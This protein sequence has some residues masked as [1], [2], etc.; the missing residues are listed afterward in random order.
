MTKG[1]AIEPSGA[2]LE[3]AAALDQKYLVIPNPLSLSRSLRSFS[4][5]DRCCSS[6]P[7]PRGAPP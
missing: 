6:T 1:E 3:G 2:G 7:L 4:S 5:R